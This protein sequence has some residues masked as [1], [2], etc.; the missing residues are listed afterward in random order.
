[1]GAEVNPRTLSRPS[2]YNGKNTQ[3]P[4][5]L[6]ATPWTRKGYPPYLQSSERDP[7]KPG[8]GAYMPKHVGPKMPNPKEGRAC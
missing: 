8:V 2:D 6:N 3:T 5:M 4:D 7:A 1:M